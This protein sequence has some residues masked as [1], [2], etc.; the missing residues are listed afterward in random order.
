[1]TALFERPI[2]QKCSLLWSVTCSALRIER[3]IITISLELFTTFFFSDK[4]NLHLPSVLP[5]VLL[6]LLAAGRDHGHSCLTQTESSN[7]RSR[8]DSA[9]ICFSS[10]LTLID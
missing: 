7:T 2:T 9:K 3:T 4:I 5:F 8:T 1:M 10:G 6:T